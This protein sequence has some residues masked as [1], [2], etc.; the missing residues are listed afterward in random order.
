LPAWRIHSHSDA[1]LGALAL[2]APGPAT[3]IPVACIYATFAVVALLL[4]R[5]R[6]ECGCFGESEAP[7]SR[8]QGLLNVTLMA[9]SLAAAVHQ[10]HGLGWIVGQP[11][12]MLGI[13]GAAFAIV[14]AYTEL[15]RAWSAWSAP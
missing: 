7:A 11:V 4:L 13:A 3:A 8:L 1:S 2:L 9:V 15:P 10:P 5:R 12:L 14:L 6:S